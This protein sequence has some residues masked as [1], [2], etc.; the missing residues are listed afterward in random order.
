MHQVNWEHLSVILERQ[1]QQKEE[2]IAMLPKPEDFSRL[3]RWRARWIVPRY[4]GTFPLQGW[5]QPVRVF[6]FYCNCGKY[7]VWH[8]GGWKDEL[9]CPDWPPFS[10]INVGNTH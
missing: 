9:Q 4:V 6:L 7:H 8:R 2:N 10:K 1:W 3:Q 5:D